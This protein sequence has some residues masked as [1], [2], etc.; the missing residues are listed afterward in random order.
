MKK[1]LILLA[2]FLPAT[3]WAGGWSLDGGASDINFV[4]VK[5]GKIAEVHHFTGLNGSIEGNRASVSIDLSTVESGIGIRNKRMKSMLFEVASF[6]SALI[7]ADL[8]GI[9]HK[10]L[11]VGETLSATVPLRL[12]L[13]G[14]KRELSA[15]ILV[16]ALADNRLLITSR[17]PVIVKAADYGLDAGI[18]ALRQVAR[19]P[20]ITQVVPV[21]FQL[22]FRLGN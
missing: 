21:S 7:A 2:M 6:A 18:E 22:Q 15:Q 11:K 12:D 10:T 8:T 13:H 16:I 1:L 4:S 9:N 5:K 20:S 19:L 14:V 3:V 17:E